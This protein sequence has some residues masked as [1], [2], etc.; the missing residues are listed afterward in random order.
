MG[1]AKISLV[2]VDKQLELRVET[3]H[4]PHLT[5]ACNLSIITAWNEKQC[6]ITADKPASMAYDLFEDFD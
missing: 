3:L 6:N 4:R 1:E 5:I 2:E